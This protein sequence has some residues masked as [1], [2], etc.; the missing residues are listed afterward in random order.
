MNSM[1]LFVRAV[2]M[3]LCAA[4][5]IGAPGATPDEVAGAAA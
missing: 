1:R 2:L 5:P 3:L 4:I